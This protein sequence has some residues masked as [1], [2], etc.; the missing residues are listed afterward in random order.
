MK[1]IL[2]FLAMALVQGSTLFQLVKFVRTKQTLGVS[3]AFWW[4]VWLGL[5]LY[6]VYAI[7]IKDPIYITSNCIGITLTG[8]S[9]GLYYKYRRR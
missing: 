5:V 4:C 7:L 9:I 1:L 8:T 3:I 2:G 6:L